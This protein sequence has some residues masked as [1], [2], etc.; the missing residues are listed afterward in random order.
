MEY[1]LKKKA[2]ETGDIYRSYIYRNELH[3]TCF[4]HNM[5][6]GDFKDLVRTTALDKVLRDKAFDISK[7]QKYDEYQ[8]G[9]ASM[10]FKFFHKKSSGSGV[11]GG[12][13]QNER[14]LDLAMQK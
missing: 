11:N 1:L 14:P 3:K 9:L 7:N 13:K 10:I 8:R 6:Y 4:Q 12:V 5:A 2:K